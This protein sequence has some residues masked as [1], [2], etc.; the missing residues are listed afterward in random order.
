M[1]RLGR[2]LGIPARDVTH[3]SPLLVNGARV[4]MEAEALHQQRSNRR[5]ERAQVERQRQAAAAKQH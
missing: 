2:M 1:I 5:A 3:E 4:L